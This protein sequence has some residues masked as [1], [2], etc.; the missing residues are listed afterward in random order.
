MPR[1]AAH[2][3]A[4]IGCSTTVGSRPMDLVLLIL[5]L[6]GAGWGLATVSAPCRAMIERYC[7]GGLVAVA[8]GPHRCT[9]M[10]TT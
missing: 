10:F 8:Y 7:G 1:D 9:S 3:F 4:Q 5:L 2:A 6:L